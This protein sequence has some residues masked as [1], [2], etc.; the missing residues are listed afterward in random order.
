MTFCREAMCL[1]HGEALWRLW[2]KGI[3]VMGEQNSPPFCAGTL[4]P[5]H[6]V[7][8]VLDRSWRE[9]SLREGRCCFSGDSCSGTALR[10]QA[11]PRVQNSAS[12]VQNPYSDA[13]EYAALG[14]CCQSQAAVCL[15]LCMKP[16]LPCQPLVCPWNCEDL[17]LLPG[18]LSQSVR[19]NVARNGRC[20]HSRNLFPKLWYRHRKYENS[21]TLRA[22]K[23][24]NVCW[25]KIPVQGLNMQ[26]K[27]FSGPTEPCCRGLSCTAGAH[28]PSARALCLLSPATVRITQRPNSGS[29]KCLKTFC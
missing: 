26:C 23:Q 18:L 1:G 15:S 2:T 16:F 13:L 11:A 5:S 6:Q 8:T 27:F 4:S 14:G 17:S 19:R 24:F 28:M 21:G 3:Q 7:P 22:S 29:I 9:V 10:H 25:E 12:Q 20:C